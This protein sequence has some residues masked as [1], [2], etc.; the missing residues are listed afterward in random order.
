[1]RCDFAVGHQHRC[2]C[3]DVS[4][5]GSLYRYHYGTDVDGVHLDGPGKFHGST[6]Y[7][8]TVWSCQQHGTALH[9]FRVRGSHC[10]S[11]TDLAQSRNFSVAGI[12]QFFVRLRH[13]IRW[14]TVLF[15]D[16]RAM[17][18]HWFRHAG[19]CSYDL[20]SFYA[21]NKQWITLMT[22]CLYFSF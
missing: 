14:A 12:S 18:K 4:G 10:R 1:M 5:H 2:I 22:L 8:S 15:T 21:F 11:G 16:G 7:W 19:F 20:H 13:H 17:L 6:S 9:M 3:Y